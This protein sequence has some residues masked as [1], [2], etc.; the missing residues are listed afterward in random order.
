MSNLILVVDDDWALCAVI[1]DAL[2]RAGLA[3]RVA[4][5]GKQCLEAVAAERPDVVVL[6]IRMP[7]MDGYETLRELRKNPKTKL[8]P[9]VI[10]TGHPGEPGETAEGMAEVNRYLLKPCD[11]SRLVSAVKELLPTPPGA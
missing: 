1:Q 2:Q 3:V 4:H 6:D 10:L 9:V 8:L 11:L 7:V 5:D